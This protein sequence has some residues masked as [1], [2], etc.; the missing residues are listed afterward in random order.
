M[1][2]VHRVPELR[3]LVAR[4][5]RDGRQVGLVPTMGALHDGHLALVDRARR[6][7][8]LVIVSIFVNPTQ[9]RPGEDLDRY[10]RQLER[11]TELAAEHGAD[12]IFAPDAGEVYRP[13]HATTVSIAGISET[14]CGDAGRRGREH[15]DGVATIVAKLFNMAQP[16]RAYFG[17]KDAQQLA[18]IKTM[19]AD[20]DMPV[21]VIAC[22]TVREQDGLAMSSRNAYLSAADR[23]RATALWRA[24]QIAQ[25]CVA[26]GERDSQKVLAA[27]TPALG[28]LDSVEYFELVDPQSMQPVQHIDA[29]VLA[30]IAARCGD[31]RLIDNLLLE[32]VSAPAGFADGSGGVVTSTTNPIPQG[33]AV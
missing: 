7:N 3:E 25:E 15:F 21:E 29:P 31:T 8:D 4:A 2:T 18:V 11:D 32:P 22:P 10:P 14:L 23:Q 5:R 26:A 9:F 28:V 24:L 27:A 20:L 17:Q 16:D 13:G 6:E 19:V 33:V 30:A 1:Q 12:V